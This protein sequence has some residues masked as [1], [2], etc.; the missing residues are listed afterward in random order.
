MWRVSGASQMQLAIA[1]EK[2]AAAY[3]KQNHPVE[4]NLQF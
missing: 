1:H 2:N 4:I 3:R